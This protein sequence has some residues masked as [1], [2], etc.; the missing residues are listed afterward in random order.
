MIGSLVWALV[1]AACTAWSLRVLW[2]RRVRPLHV[3]RTVVARG[4]RT[5]RRPTA[6]A[7]G[8]HWADVLDAIAAEV[9]AGTSLTVAIERT[10]ARVL[11]GDAAVAV[12]TLGVAAA[13]G[14]PVSATIRQ[15]A[16]VLRDR[17]AAQA[18]ALAHSAQARLSAT[19]LTVLPIA[20]TGV[21]FATSASFRSAALSSAG[22][23]ALC[24]GVT[25]NLIGR[26]WMRRL[27]DR[28]T[29]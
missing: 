28:S 10:A 27:V 6:D 15:G 18:E 7:H 19:V 1:A 2:P 21:A 16:L 14:G 5:R 12:H 3:D 4:H 8:D 25:L 29:R 20:F 26:R 17:H 23:I 22:L 24:A 9:R 13:V 11:H